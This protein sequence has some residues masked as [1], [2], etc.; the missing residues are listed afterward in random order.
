MVQNVI[1][2]LKSWLKGK[3][4]SIGANPNGEASVYGN[5]QGN[6]KVKEEEQSP[7]CVGAAKLRPI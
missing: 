6:S 3:G 7:G 1:N 2:D 5:K 4:V